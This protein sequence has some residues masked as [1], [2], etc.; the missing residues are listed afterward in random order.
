MPECCRQVTRLAV[1]IES[2]PVSHDFFRVLGV[3]PALGRNFSSTDEQVNAAPVVIL[4]DHVWRDHL[5]ANPRII[6]QMIRLNGRAIR[7]SE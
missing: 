5:G 4:S 7:L 2:A 3:S 6:G 1:Q